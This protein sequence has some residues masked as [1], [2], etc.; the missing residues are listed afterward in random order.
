MKRLLLFSFISIL[1]LQ[2][3]SAQSPLSATQ[4]ISAASTQAKQENK[5]IFVIF[6]ASWCIWCR[7]MDTAMNDPAIA[8]YFSDNYVVKHMTVLESAKK[9]QLENPGAEELMNRYGGKN[10]GLPFWIILDNNG[11]YLF[12]SR[13]R[14]ADGKP[15]ENVGCP[16]SEKEVAHLIAVLQKSSTINKEGL[17]A[18]RKR[19]RKIETQ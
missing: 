11:D 12:D 13:E 1:A 6:H 7:R 10:E 14:I 3:M 9:K 4:I 19:F 17:E 15:A 8:R 18:I 5:N 16:A 2:S